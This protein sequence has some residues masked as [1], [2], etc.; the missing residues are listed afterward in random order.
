MSAKQTTHQSGLTVKFVPS[1]VIT[2]EM[3]TLNVP[4]LTS[5]LRKPVYLTNYVKIFHMY[6]VYLIESPLGNTRD[7]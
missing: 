5:I 7:V 3:S 6:I 1:T 2:T 4:S